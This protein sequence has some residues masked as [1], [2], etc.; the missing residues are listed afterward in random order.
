MS[1]GA[2]DVIV[3]A[4]VDRGGLLQVPAAG[5]EPEPLTRVDGEDGVIAHLWPH[6]LPNGKGVLF[7]A[8]AGSSESS[9]IAVVSETGEVRPLI[10][11]GSDA[12]YLETGHLVYG[13]GETLRAVGFD[14]DTLEVTGDPVPVLEDVNTKLTGA[15]NFSLSTSGSLVYV[16]GVSN[17]LSPVWVDREGRE[18][19]LPL[20]RGSYAH[21]R[22]SPTDDR[23]AVELVGAANRDIWIF[24]LTREVFTQ[25][26]FDDAD[27]THP[28]W[29]PDGERIVFASNRDGEPG[30]FSVAADGSTAVERL[31]DG[32]VE[33]EPYSWSADGAT[34][35]L[36]E[37][38]GT[39]GISVLS[40]EGDPRIEPL[41]RPPFPAEYPRVSPDGRW[42]AYTANEPIGNRVY[43]R[44]FPDVDSERWP[45]SPG[46][47][48]DPVWGEDELFYTGPRGAIM[49]VGIEIEP[50]FQAG[51]PQ[52]LFSGPYRESSG[53]QYDATR[54]GQRFLMLRQGGDGAT[55]EIAVITN[56][57]EEL[58]R[59]VPTN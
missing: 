16:R 49:A 27:D 43:V 12:R 42:I 30:L 51:T 52:Q 6:V 57:F 14:Q 54:D 40:M 3:F 17:L 20:D 23:I 31:T 55:P 25:L 18:E 38:P 26:T 10:S 29:T 50:A 35:V 53:V 8:W 11:G 56:W 33:Q 48:D 21:P 1:W 22:L 9:R 2:D 19:P 7:T 59:L 46:E 58:K 24:D 5:G 4:T 39:V 13:V 32:G 15:G 45:I 41:L 34:L 28:I 44:P 47:G 36:N 37:G